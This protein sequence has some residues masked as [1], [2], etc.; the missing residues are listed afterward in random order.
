MR[1]IAGT[2]KGMKLFTPH[3]N[4]SRPILDRVKE[5]LFSVLF[6]YDMPADKKVAD[7]FSGVGS[8]GLESLSRGA[9]EAVFAEKHRRIISILEKN[10]SK[11]GFEA[12]SRI[13]RTN[14]FKFGQS[15]QIADEKFDLIFVDPPY[16]L[17]KSVHAKTRTGKLLENL[18][19]R[20]Y[21]DGVIVLRTEG[22]TELPEDFGKLGV[23]ENRKWLSMNLT[24]LGLKKDG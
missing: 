24:I 11:A 13:V 23:I 8:M 22:S 1:I 10:I 3:N 4:V 9:S 20:I 6:K 16:A 2:K 19:D 17:T 21:A 7:L 14:A 12:R 15:A 5:S 18:A